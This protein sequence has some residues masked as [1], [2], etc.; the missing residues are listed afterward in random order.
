M[1]SFLCP[2]ALRDVH[3]TITAKQGGEC[4]HYIIF[5][6]CRRPRVYTL[7]GGIILHCCGRIKRFTIKT[8]APIL[9]LYHIEITVPA[10]LV[11]SCVKNGIV[12]FHL[13]KL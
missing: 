2:S 3:S 7:G 9:P 13:R 5:V 6:S 12:N 8:N 4:A 11:N 1:L 10:Y